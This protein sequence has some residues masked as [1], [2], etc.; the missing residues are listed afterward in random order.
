MFLM[1]LLAAVH[2]LTTLSDAKFIQLMAG[3]GRRNWYG[4]LVGGPG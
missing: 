4:A 3:E 2:S 1:N